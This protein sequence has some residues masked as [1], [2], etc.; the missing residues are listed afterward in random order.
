MI[1]FNLIDTSFIHHKSVGLPDYS[2]AGKYSKYMFWD[3]NQTTENITFLTNEKCLVSTNLDKKNR[4]GFLFESQSIIPQVY[5]EIENKIDDF[6]KVFTHSSYLINKFENCL[7]I[8]GGGIW[9][10]GKYGLGEI[11]IYDKTK[12]C[13]IVTSN[14][15]LCDLHK[16]RLE[17]TNYIRQNNLDVTIFGLSSWTPII[18][19]L[20]DFM[21]SIIIENFV[22]ELYFTEKILNCFATGVVPIYLGAKKITTKF[23]KNGIITFSTLNELEE[24]IKNL[25]AELYFSKMEAIKENFE[26]CQQY[27]LIEDYI[28]KNYF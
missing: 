5:K 4:F 20:K 15:K 26:K 10:G 17:V 7:W 14:K 28:Y 1:R 8:P 6:Q 24:I 9:V 23:N 21:F 16:F 11:K 2:V 27:N 22:D 12:V 18:D 3:R 25:N 19:S 13:S